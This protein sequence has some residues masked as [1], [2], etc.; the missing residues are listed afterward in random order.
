MRKQIVLIALII[1]F[2][3]SGVST[4][5]WADTREKKTPPAT[6]PIDVTPASGATF[7]VA[8]ATGTSTT[9][10]QPTASNLNAQVSGDVANAMADSGNTV[11]IGARAY[12]SFPAPVDDGQRANIASDRFGRLVVVPLQIRGLLSQANITVNTATETT[13]LAAIGATTFQDLV[14]LSC[15]NT[16]ATA[17]RVDVRDTTAGPVVTQL[18]IPAGDTRHFVYQVPFRQTNPNTNWTIQLTPAVTDVR[19][20]IQAVQNGV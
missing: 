13:L 18:L 14:S 9:V 5:S 19:C 12:R 3:I 1:A 11:K 6:G 15:A 8:P 20:V 2:G 16:S 7:T 10:A 4:K 17:T